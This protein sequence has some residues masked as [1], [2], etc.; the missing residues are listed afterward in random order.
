VLCVCFEFLIGYTHSSMNVEAKMLLFL[1][2]KKTI[3]YLIISK[4]CL[5]LPAK[6]LDS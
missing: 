6:W 5:D 4:G 3:S 2:L 1:N